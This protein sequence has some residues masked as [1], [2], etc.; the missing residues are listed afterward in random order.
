MS[1]RVLA[2]T[3]NVIQTLKK[4]NV[5]VNKVKLSDKGVDN[6]ASTLSF[7]KGLNRPGDLIPATVV[8]GNG[9]IGYTCDIFENGID[10]PATKQ[11]TVFLA[12]GGGSLFELP[13]GT[14]LFVQKYNVRVFGGVN[15]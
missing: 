7:T 3:D 12:N 13:V 9:V 4:A 1:T 11:G 14:R 8:S 2:A 10:Q 6:D 15:D 5:L